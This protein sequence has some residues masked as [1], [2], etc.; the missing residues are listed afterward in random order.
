MPR[1]TTLAFMALPLLALSLAYYAQSSS[2]PLGPAP[3]LGTGLQFSLALSSLIGYAQAAVQ[4]P[5]RFKT[6]EQPA[7]AVFGADE[8]D[9]A[10]EPRPRFT[11]KIIAVGDIHGDI[12]NAEH[13][14]QMAGVVDE[15][16][17]WSGNVDVFVQTGDII[18][19]GDDTI[20]L[21]NW[22]EDLREQ[23]LAV[24]GIVLSI[25][26]NHEYMNAIGDW[27]Y[28]LESEKKTFEPRD[29][30]LEAVTTGWLADAW[31][32]NYTTAARLPLHGL[33][34]PP[35]TDY[36]APDGSA[37]ARANAGPLSHAA[38]SFV[39]GGLAPT[40]PN[41]Q[42][43]P[44]AI[45][46]IGSSLLRRLRERKPQP[47]PHPPSSYPGLPAG[48][49]REEARMY[50]ADGPLWYRGWA[51]ED[52]RK[53]CP[54]VDA[55]LEKTGTR[56]MVMG[57]TPQFDG[58]LAKCDGK[59]IIID[60]GI[61]HAYNGALS[62]LSIEYTLEPVKGGGWKEKEIVKALYADQDD[63]LLAESTRDLDG[64]LW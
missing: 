41:L 2:S 25:L 8:D 1:G 64:D 58:I 4:A 29:S 21:F 7:E 11:R 60:T 37:F 61:S 24:N 12:G 62:A 20:E 35:N 36:P 27:R 10:R 63:E 48:T 9:Y 19:R 23:A 32:A 6:V 16:N 31:A 45:N 30:R 54:M 42:P 46:G 49:T 50:S 17:N 57:H 13:I 44:S 26:G 5:F 55:V 34:G 53:V 22:M 47:L 33:L 40:Y 18:D 38:F 56:R 59:V 39:H 43:F 52:D 14:L 3:H 51:D 15:N 28:V